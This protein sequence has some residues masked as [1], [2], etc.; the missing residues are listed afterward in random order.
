MNSVERI[1]PLIPKFK[2]QLIFLE[3][4]EKLFKKIDD[5]SVPFD[6][7]FSNASTNVQTS[8]V[9]S[10]DSLS[11]SMISIDSQSSSMV[12]INSQSLSFVPAPTNGCLSNQCM[13]NSRSDQYGVDADIFIPFSD[14]YKIPPLP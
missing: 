10:I 11:S 14:N 5:Y 4:R 13:E 12:S 2:Q 6:G 7:S 8:S 1:S 9:V 3:E